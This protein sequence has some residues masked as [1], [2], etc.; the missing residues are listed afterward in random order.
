MRVF[1]FVYVAWMLTKSVDT[2]GGVEAGEGRLAR[3][4]FGY[5]CPINCQSI[6]YIWHGCGLAVCAMDE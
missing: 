2:G 4:L 5:C 1:G 3:F 6:I